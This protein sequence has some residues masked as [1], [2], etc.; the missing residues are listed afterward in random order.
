[1]IIK[2][3]LLTRANMEIKQYKWKITICND[4][5]FM[6]C[7]NK[8]VNILFYKLA[9]MINTLIIDVQQVKAECHLNV[10]LNDVLLSYVITKESETDMLYRLCHDVNV[11]KDLSKTREER[12]EKL[13]NY[14][15]TIMW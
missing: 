8:K 14:I 9:E 12:L 11:S 10:Y 5:Q 4:Y 6:L 2:A 13:L 1:M 7:A 15:G 3:S